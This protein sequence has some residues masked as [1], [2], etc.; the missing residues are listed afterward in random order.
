MMF[1][2]EIT[3]QVLVGSFMKDFVGPESS[4]IFEGRIVRYLHET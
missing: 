3:N 4:H 1:T 2:V